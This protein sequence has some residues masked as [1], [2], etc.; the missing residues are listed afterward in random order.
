MTLRHL[1][2]IKYLLGAWRADVTA[3]DARGD[4]PLHLCRGPLEV[5]TLLCHGSAR[6]PSL[7][8]R[9]AEGQTPVEAIAAA[10]PGNAPVRVD[11]A[12]TC[13]HLC[14]PVKRLGGRSPGTVTLA[15]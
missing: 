3:A 7:S 13:A 2:T 5:L 10:S 9:N 11:S 6:K 4:T 12:A 15:E 14:P 1:I 8:A